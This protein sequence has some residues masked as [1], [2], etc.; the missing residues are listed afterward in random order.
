MSYQ[1]VIGLE[2]HVELKTKTKLFC[3]CKNSFGGA[4]NHRICPI[5]TGQ[6]GT[7]PHIN[8]EA[9]RLAYFAAAAL[10]CTSFEASKQSR[11]HYFYPDLPKG[12]QISQNELP[13]ARNG[14]FEYII[15]GEVRTVGI[16]NVHLEEDA[17]KLVHNA[18]NETEIDYNRA[19][20]PLIEIVTRP[21]LRYPYEV[22]AFLEALRIYLIRCGVSEC[23]MQEGAL[24]CDV[25]VSLRRHG[26]KRLNERVEMKNVNTFSGAERAVAYEIARQTDILKSGSTVEPQT[27]RWDD[28]QRKS[29]VLRTKEN[30]IDY[31]YMPDPDIPPYAV[32]KSELSELMKRVPENDVI[33]R[34][35]FLNAGITP[36][37]AD[38]ILSD[39]D[40]TDFAEECIRLNGCAAECAKFLT[41]EISSIRIPLSESRLTPGQLVYIANLI[42]NGKINRGGAKAIILKLMSDGGNEKEIS[43]DYIFETSQADMEKAAEEVICENEKVVS[44]YLGGKENAIAFLMGKCMRKLG[45]KAPANELVKILQMQI[46]RYK[47]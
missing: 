3:S 8:A 14:K 35:R 31:K 29:F 25:N 40:M 24:R 22:R 46:E 20:V 39:T 12:Y 21:D 32:K 42:I 9:V 34:K 36:A 47:S 2:I 4:P 7:L 6:P 17:G 30:A 10:G 23:R 38:V 18:G 1:S 44:D 33:K 15:D 41:N 27:R 13:I 19:G 16:D 26:E 28:I 43:R 45:K 11:K 5:C 37:D